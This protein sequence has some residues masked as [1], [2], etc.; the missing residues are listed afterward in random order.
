M[1]KRRF[2]KLF[3]AIY[4]L[5]AIPYEGFSE[6]GFWNFG[7]APK[8]MIEQRLGVKID[9]AWLQRLSRATARLSNGGTG[10]FISRN[11][12]VATNQH[13]AQD[14]AQEISAAKTNYVK[15]GYMARDQSAELKLPDIELRVLER[16]EDVTQRVNAAKTAGMSALESRDA[17]RRESVKIAQEREETTG[18]VT[19]VVSSFGG[20]THTLYSYKVYKDVRLVFLPERGIANFGG[21]EDNYSYPRYWLD[22]A[23]LRVY[24]N[25]KPLQTD[26]YLPL[27][28]QGVKDK[29]PVFVAGYPI[30][31]E[32]YLTASHLE[33]LSKTELPLVIKGLRAQRAALRSYSETGET[34]ATS[35]QTQLFDLENTLKALEGRV[36]GMTRAG[37]LEGRRKTEEEWRRKLTLQKTG[38]ERYEQAFAAIENARRTLATYEAERRMLD[39][40]WGFDTALFQAAREHVRLAQQKARPPAERLPGI[41]DGYLERLEKHILSGAPE[42][43]KLEELK[44][45][46]SLTLMQDALGDSHPIVKAAL[47][48]KSPIESAAELLGATRLDDLNFRRELVRQGIQGLDK[49]TD[50][51]IVLARQVDA[52]ALLLRQRYRKEV[53]EVEGENYPRIAAAMQIILGENYYPDA[54]FTLRLSVGRV[55]GYAENNRLIPPFTFFGELYDRAGRKKNAAP[56]KLPE[57]WVE[58]KKALDLGAP[59]NFIL[60]NDVVGGNSGSPVVNQK[61][62]LVGIIFDSNQ[63]ALV[64]R[65]FYEGARGRAIALDVRGM[66]AALRDVYRAEAL[67]AELQ[68]TGKPK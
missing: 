61:G 67:L 57:L 12:L 68:P 1:L 47:A 65:Y 32:R 20:S 55:K 38:A 30:T 51:M 8:K 54:N 45:A 27:A 3:V 62:E 39:E 41:D 49:S 23:L 13:V 50:P 28:R 63:H 44:L 16:Q 17:V 18:L 66:L 24:E 25:D 9:D 43:G 2:V 64:G 19:D 14:F 33:Y 56:Y 34:E 58:R 37:V 42:K 5:T 60:T 35:V 52:Q 10:V 40:Q 46:N 21:D 6:E 4:I 53:L 22:V 36:E 26:N 15:D 11:G 31:T 59:F 7:V 48:G 29:E